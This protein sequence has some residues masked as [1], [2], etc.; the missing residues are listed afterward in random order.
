MF[1]VTKKCL[2]L[3]NYATQEI[4]SLVDVCTSVFYFENESYIQNETVGDSAFASRK[5]YLW[6]LW[7]PKYQ[8]QID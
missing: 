5:I 3:I 2:N 1:N 7:K 8:V 4:I 6:I